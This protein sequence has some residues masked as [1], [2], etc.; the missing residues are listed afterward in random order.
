MA[1][2]DDFNLDLRGGLLDLPTERFTIRLVTDE[3]AAAAAPK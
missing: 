2:D 1:I 3:Q